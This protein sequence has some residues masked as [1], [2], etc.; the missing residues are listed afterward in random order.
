[1]TSERNLTDAV[2]I[3]DA[4]PEKIALVIDTDDVLLGTITDGDIRRGLL[5]SLPMTAPVTEVMRQ[6]FTAATTTDDDERLLEL[7][8]QNVVRQIPILD[9][10]GRIIGLTIEDDLTTPAPKK[11]NWVVLMA[12]GLGSRLRPM[13]DDI[14]KPLL[15]VGETPLLETILKTFVDHQFHNFYISVNYRADLVEAHF[16]NGERWGVDIKYLQE[17]QQL[18]TGGAL[19]LLPAPPSDPVIVMNGDVLTKVNFN[20]LLD[21]HREQ[22]SKA[23]MGVREYDLEVPFGV[24]EIENN[25]VIGIEEKPIHTFFI[26]AGIY[27]L[28][29]DLLSLVA[30]GEHLDMTELFQKVI[31]A[32]MRTAVFPVRE[33]WMDI[34][35]LDDFQQA[36]G[37]FPKHFR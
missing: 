9:G 34:G 3:I 2:A 5:R 23:T 11:D 18:G 4:S 30:P 8:R 26:N 32:K 29:P 21:F 19:G 36:N 16:G 22:G 31:D 35:K 7:M 13:T 28:D 6:E 27:V 10:H 24:V 15:K 1:M 12:G 17:D 20:H 14:P 37:D 25:S 33:Y